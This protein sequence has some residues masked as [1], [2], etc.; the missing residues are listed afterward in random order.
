MGE[1]GD[2]EFEVDRVI[3]HRRKRGRGR[4]LQYLVLWKGYD[5]SEATWEAEDAMEHA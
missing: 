3:R 1:S 4:G 5:L 2:V